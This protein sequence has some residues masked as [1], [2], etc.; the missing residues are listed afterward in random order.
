MNKDIE[1]KYNLLQNILH[2]MNS[3]IIA[4]SGGIDSTLLAVVAKEVLQENTIAVCNISATFP[5]RELEHA[6]KTAQLMG[7]RFE[8]IQ[9]GELDDPMFTANPQNRCY[10]CKTHLFK[11]LLIH[12]VKNNI[13]WIVEGSNMDDLN[14]YRPGFQA[15]KEQNIRSPLI[16]AKFSKSEIRILAKYKNIRGWDKPSSACLASRIPYHEIIS[17]KRLEKIEYAEDFLLSLDFKVVRVRDFNSIAVIE[18]GKNEL[19]RLLDVNL[20]KTISLNVKSAGFDKVFIDLD[21]YKTGSLN[22][23]FKNANV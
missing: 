12:A 23:K 19:N 18:L 8:T 4:Y 16:E 7:L 3:V 22:T 20:R 10:I 9:T 13:K 11:A 1:K 17:P 2:K 14:D 5:K 15:V 6:K 21:G